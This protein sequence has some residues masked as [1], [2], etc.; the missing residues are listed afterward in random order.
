[1]KY[2]IGIVLVSSLSLII[3]SCNLLEPPI[4]DEP[5]FISYTMAGG[6]AGAVDTKLSISPTGFVRLESTYPVLE[7]QLTDQDH[8]SLRERFSGFR[9]L[10]EDFPAQV[11][12]DFFH[13]IERVGED[14]SK[15][16]VI[17][18][19]ALGQMKGD[20]SVKQ[21]GNIV[22]FLRALAKNMYD[23]QAPW[24]GLTAS[25]SINAEVYGLGE[26]I[27]LTYRVS[28]PTGLQRGLYF[29]NQRQ[30]SFHVY[31]PSIPSFHYFFPDPF[32][33]DSSM[34]AEIIL[35]PGETK[36]LIYEWD[37][38]IS[39]RQGQESKLDIGSYRVVMRFLAG[40]F[41]W[42]VFPFEVVDHSGNGSD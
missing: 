10:R 5:A 17:S 4:P 27:T 38:T 3:Q 20:L 11:I 19:W 2:T 24:V 33:A 26:P 16:V 7:R 32:V 36:E 35:Q 31:K 40:D 1:M 15:R 25:F 13:I 9:S 14:Y 18:S 41:P 39:T 23:T 37:Q 28:N 12:D 34:P 30:L 8:R 21:I 42:Q 6:I 29:K 22:S